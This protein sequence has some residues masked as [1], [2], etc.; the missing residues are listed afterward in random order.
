MRKPRF[1]VFVAVPGIAF[2][3]TVA[4]AAVPTGSG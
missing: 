3:A 2:G 4:Y 1:A